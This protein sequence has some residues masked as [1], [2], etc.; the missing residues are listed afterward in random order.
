MFPSYL[1][2]LSG[3]ELGPKTMPGDRDCTHGSGSGDE[4]G[5][6]ARACEVSQLLTLLMVNLLD[7]EKCNFTLV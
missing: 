7:E 5:R 1:V 4:L 2:Q 3:R 6:S